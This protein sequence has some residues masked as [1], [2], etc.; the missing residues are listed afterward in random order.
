MP[1]VYGPI[2][3]LKNELRNAAV[4]NLGS[5]PSAPVKG[6]L[7]MDS[8]NNILKWWDGSQ[9]V[10]AMGGAGAV[11]GDTATTAAVGDASAGGASSL[12][13][14]A[15]H[16]HGM[17]GFAATTAQTSFG[18][19]KN[20]GAATTLARSDHVHGTPA[21][22]AAAHSAIPLNSYAVPTGSLNL[23]SQKITSLA[24]GT[25][26][27]D[28]ANLGQLQNMVAGLS[29][30][31]EVRAAT[32]ANI[33]LS[34]PQT[35]DG[36]AVIA[37]ERVLVKN[38]T[39]TSANGIYTVAAGA[40]VRATDADSSAEL[41]NA[42]V[43]VSEGTT[44]AD[45]AWT[46]TVNGPITVGTTGLTFVQFGGGSSIT[47]GAGLLFSGNV[48]NIGAGA[49]IAVAADSVAVDFTTPVAT[50]TV[51]ARKFAAALTGTS[52]PETVTHNLGTRDIHLQVYNGSTPY[53]A[54]DVDWDATTT[55]TAVIRYAP[56]LGSGYRVSVVG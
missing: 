18:A 1:S 34:A 38:Q 30:K 15:D 52:S 51:V 3:L 2:D 25:V 5:A 23:N 39:T 17:P 20:D 27:T 54:V 19:A 8:T 48:L 10:S 13:S 45:T 33:T 46:Q 36:V 11:P 40:W 6:Q 53:T 24:D 28:A 35:I 16:K 31:D 37:N 14:R 22:D 26:A 12:Y 42:A 21:H 50:G 56:N 29:W 49:G 55:N 7:W 9:W 41:V 32:T 4:Q 43:F 47:D 44:Q